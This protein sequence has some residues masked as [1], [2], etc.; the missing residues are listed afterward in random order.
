M[1][2][3][4]ADFSRIELNY[5]LMPA[6]SIGRWRRWAADGLSVRARQYRGAGNVRFGSEPVIRP[7]RLN[8]RFAPLADIHFRLACAVLG[9]LDLFGLAAGGFLGAA[10][11]LSPD[12]CGLRAFVLKAVL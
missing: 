7:G 6:R 2:K 10:L 9:R 3:R 8:V 1:T 5:P 12:R 11:D 4:S